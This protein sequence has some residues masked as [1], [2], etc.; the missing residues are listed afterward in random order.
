[1]AQPQSADKFRR[2]RARRKAEGLKEVRLW[3]RDPTAP[4]FRAEI[5]RQVGVLA[6]APEEDE[7]MREIAAGWAGLEEDLDRPDKRA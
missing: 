6:G 2:F 4:N 3:V 5:E 1:M 7:V